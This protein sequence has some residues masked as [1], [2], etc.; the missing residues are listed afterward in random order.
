MTPFEYKVCGCR[1]NRTGIV[2]DPE[3]IL[4]TKQYFHHHVDYV[5]SQVLK[6]L[7]LTFATTFSFSSTYSLLV[8]QL[9]SVRCNVEYAPTAYNTPTSPDASELSAF[10]GSF[11]SVLQSFLSSNSLQLRECLPFLIQQ[12][13]PL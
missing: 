9:V 12:K 8:L 3:I 5:F 2:K 10:S 11:C 4:D 1:I 13:A 7:G 6:L